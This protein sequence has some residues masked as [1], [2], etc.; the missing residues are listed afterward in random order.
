M[1]RK[2]PAS[3]RACGIAGLRVFADSPPT[4]TTQHCE[5][6]GIPTRKT[7]CSTCRAWCDA[8]RHIQLAARA[9]RRGEDK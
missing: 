1:K 5:I 4:Y 3:G 7:P 9:L 2:N 8:G 6:C